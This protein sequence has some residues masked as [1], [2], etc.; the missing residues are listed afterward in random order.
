MIFKM[1]KHLIFILI[2]FTGCYLASGQPGKTLYKSDTECTSLLNQAG[3]LFNEGQYLKCISDLEGVLKSCD[4]SKSEKEHAMELLARAYIEVDEPGKADAAVKRLLVRFPHYE[5]KESDNSELYNRLVK[6]YQIHPLV[7]IGVRNT[8][9]T[10]YYK[11]TNVYTVLPGLDNT[12]PYK[13]LGSGFMYYGWGEIEFKKDISINGDLI[14]FWTRYDRY[15]KKPPGF[16]QHFWEVNNFMQIPL[17]LKKYFHIGKNVLPYVTAG[18]S[19]QY[20]YRATGYIDLTYTKNDVITGKNADF[21][22]YWY[23][24][25]TMDMRNKNTFD[26]LAGVG[27]GYK[28]K[29]LRMFLDIRYYGGL[30][31]FTNASKRSYYP[32]LASDWFYVD[33]SVKLSQFEYGASISY[34]IFNSVKKIKH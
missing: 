34:T 3:K 5:L 19:W 33:N 20:L 21:S 32:A 1:M 30:N 9:K 23:N 28:L 16:D 26:W 27:I 6:K 15:I 4:L 10:V 11:T 31:S 22:S 12:E 7:S 17:Y 2:L 29:N 14:F 25:K 24:M 13:S 8:L 18:A